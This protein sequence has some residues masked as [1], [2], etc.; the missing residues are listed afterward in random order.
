[1][2]DEPSVIGPD[3]GVGVAVGVG[4]GVAVGAGVDLGDQIV[5]VA[6]GTIAVGMDFGVSRNR[7]LEWRDLLEAGDEVGG[8]GIS[9][10]VR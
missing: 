10:R 3:G 2:I 4:V 1:M 5:E 6:V 8:I 7:N 9:L